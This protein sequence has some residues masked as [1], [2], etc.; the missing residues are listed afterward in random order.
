MLSWVNRARGAAGI[1]LRD[2]GSESQKATQIVAW[3]KGLQA[4]LGSSTCLVDGSGG[5]AAPCQ[6][7]P[8]Q[9]DQTGAPQLTGVPAAKVL[10]AILEGSPGRRRR[11]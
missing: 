1:L 10:V 11:R 4:V 5:G 3:N 9:H 6:A 7:Q 2:L 8:L